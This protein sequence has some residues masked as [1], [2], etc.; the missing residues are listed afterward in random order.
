MI[1]MNAR[2]A[3]APERA[4]R[5]IGHARGARHR[6]IGGRQGQEGAST[7]V[8][9][10]KKKLRH[11]REVVTGLNHFPSHKPNRGCTNDALRKSTNFREPPLDLVTELLERCQKNERKSG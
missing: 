4:L 9:S 6:V 1:S 2:A 3:D 7:E 5:G 10:D 8:P 11:R